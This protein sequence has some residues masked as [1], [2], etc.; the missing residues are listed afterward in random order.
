MS[1]KRRMRKRAPSQVEVA[2]SASNSLDWDSPSTKTGTVKRRPASGDSFLQDSEEVRS[3][4]DPRE[5][6]ARL[7]DKAEN[8]GRPGES[9]LNENY[10]GRDKW[11]KCDPEPKPN[12]SV[13]FYEASPGGRGLAD[14]VGQAV[15]FR[16]VSG[17]V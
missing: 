8:P 15:A 7:R 12:R 16:G 5:R 3:W 13:S 6:N 9:R 1:S 2:K 14:D 11:D 4:G 17:N 10:S